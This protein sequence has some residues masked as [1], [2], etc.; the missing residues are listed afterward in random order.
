MVA[1]VILVVSNGTTLNYS[2]QLGYKPA[3]PWLLNGYGDCTI[4]RLWCHCEGEGGRASLTK[5]WY[6][7]IPIK[8]PWYNYN[9]YICTLTLCSVHKEILLHLLYPCSLRQENLESPISPIP[10][11]Q[12]L[13]GKVTM[14]V[15]VKFIGLFVWWWWQPESTRG[16]CP[17]DVVWVVCGPL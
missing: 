7:T 14:I 10:V 1:P 9:V 17:F 5:G 12:S 6:N 2:D 11:H 3:V 8:K 4:W 16:P 13:I 15:L